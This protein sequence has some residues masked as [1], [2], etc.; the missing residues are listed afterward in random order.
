MAAVK[1]LS[2]S[3][4]KK[5]DVKRYRDKKQ[6][7][8]DDGTTKV[9]VD[10]T[11]RPSKK[12]QVIADLLNL[13]HEKAD[14]HDALTG[15]MISATMISLIVKHFTT[16]DVKGLNSL[17]DYVE[18]FVIMTDNQYLAPIMDAFDKTELQALIDDINKQLNRWNAE[19]HKVLGEM[20]SNEGLN[21]ENKDEQIFQ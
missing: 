2:M 21:E 3:Q 11:L 12:N 7:L 9:D 5:Q 16:I 4:I 14:K 1:N 10:V 6:V 18:L 20:D 8:F 17:D 13:I 15:D 19:L